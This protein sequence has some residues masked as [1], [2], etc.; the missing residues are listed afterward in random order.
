MVRAGLLQAVQR[1]G[2]V[3]LLPSV[4]LVPAVPS[5]LLPWLPRGARSASALPRDDDTTCC[6]AR[7]GHGSGEPRPRQVHN[8]RAGSVAQLWGDASADS[9]H[10][11]LPRSFSGHSSGLPV[12]DGALS[13][14]TH[15][16]AA[17]DLGRESRLHEDCRI[18]GC[19][20]ENTDD[21]DRH[22]KPRHQ[23]RSIR[24]G[25]SRPLLLRPLIDGQSLERIAIRQLL[26]G[27]HQSVPDQYRQPSVVWERQLWTLEHG[28]VDA[29]VPL[30]WILEAR[31]IRGWRGQNGPS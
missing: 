27:D 22:G 24:R 20:D 13:S 15:V 11:C 30:G 7:S 8:R 18:E 28:P 6:P 31:L 19:P 9:H 25:Q 14:G 4:L 12:G 29:V 2:R 1:V 21:S 10:R 5:H 26:E 17:I 3:W 16:A 23:P